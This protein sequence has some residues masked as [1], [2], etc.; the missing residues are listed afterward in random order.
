MAAPS[1]LLRLV[2]PLRV[3]GTLCLLAGLGCFGAMLAFDL[4]TH[5]QGLLLRLMISFGGAWGL[6]K[7]LRMLITG[8]MRIKVSL[9]L[10]A[11]ES[12]DDWTVR[13]MGAVFALPSSLA[14]VVGIGLT[15]SAV[16]TLVQDGAAPAIEH[17]GPRKRM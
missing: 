1:L 9:L 14:L 3:A 5:L 4:S 15:F 17:Q 12:Q 8:S 2:G 6:A 11:A 10:R 7:S 16:G 13:L